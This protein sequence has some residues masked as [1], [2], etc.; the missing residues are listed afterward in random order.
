M[1]RDFNGYFRLAVTDLEGVVQR[2]VEDL[3]NVEFDTLVGTGLSGTLVIPTI[4]LRLDKKF[5]I[6]R[7]DKKN[8]H[9][10]NEWEGSFG[11]H[12][13]FVDDFIATGETMRRVKEKVS[14]IKTEVNWWDS[15]IEPPKSVGSVF[16]GVYLYHVTVDITDTKYRAGIFFPADMADS[17][18]N[19]N[20]IAREKQAQLKRENGVE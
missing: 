18:E 3:Q 11:E 9:S 10:I 20:W 17:G 14:D 1:G 15:V 4:A 2:A 16:V 5:A 7:K 6:L 8:S 12:W 19:R 13:V